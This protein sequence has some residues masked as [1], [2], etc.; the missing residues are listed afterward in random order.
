MSAR[1]AASAVFRLHAKGCVPGALV[2][3]WSQE[4][5]FD[6]DLRKLVVAPVE[7]PGFLIARVSHRSH[8]RKGERVCVEIE[9]LGTEARDFEASLFVDEHVPGA[10]VERLLELLGGERE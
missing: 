9:N 4:M 7:R 2:P 10:D 6:V 8:A 1:E 3:I 5:P